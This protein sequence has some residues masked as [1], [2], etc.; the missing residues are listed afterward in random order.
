M[1]IF[2]ILIALLSLMFMVL[3]DVDSVSSLDNMHK[4]IKENGS[5]T[6]EILLKNFQLEEV[7]V[8]F[9]NHLLTRLK[10]ALKFLNQT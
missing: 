9:S 10:Q 6:K 3:S 5:V 2:L 8:L 4:Y 1:V 7:F